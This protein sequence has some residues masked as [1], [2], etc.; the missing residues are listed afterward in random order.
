MR[1]EAIGLLLAG[2]LMMSP[3]VLA[4]EPR[5]GQ[6]IA[7]EGAPPLLQGIVAKVTLP[8]PLSAI[9]AKAGVP[10]RGDWCH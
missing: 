6:P 3:L 2:Q 10:L 5:P 8:F 4:A 7:P 9:P 1:W